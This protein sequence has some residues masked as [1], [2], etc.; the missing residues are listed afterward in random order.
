MAG[1]NEM[2]VGKFILLGL[3]LHPQAKVPFF[4]LLLIF[5]IV[6]LLGN[7]LIVLLIMADHQL[8]TPMY[9]FLSNLSFLDICYSTSSI[10]QILAYSFVEKPTVSYKTCFTQGYISLYLGM[11]E[12]L[13]LAVMAYDRFVAICNPLHYPLIINRKVC[14]QLAAVSW[15]S[16][17]LLTLVPALM[18][19][20]RFCRHIINHFVCELQ[21]LLKLVCSDIHNNEI[22]TWVSGQLVLVGPFL[23]ILVT[24]LR[25]GLAVLRIRSTQGRSK[26]FSTCGSHLAVVSIFYGTAMFMYLRPQSKS[27]ADQDKMISVFYGALTPMLNPLIYSLRNKDVKGALRRT[28]LKAMC[29]QN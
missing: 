3:S 15:A 20:K 10:P 26:A 6:T 24:Y 5:Y 4:S 13:L 27:T 25:V 17:L 21:A 18:K 29:A 12:C 23:F 7:G 14:I 9:F 28:I 19:P 1:D 16:A 11:T 8:H 22:A 2:L